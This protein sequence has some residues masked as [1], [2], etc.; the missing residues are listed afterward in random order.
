MEKLLFSDFFYI[1]IRR[2]KINWWNKRKEHQNTI[3][4]FSVSQSYS[5]EILLFFL[6]GLCCSFV[7]DLNGHFWRMNPQRHKIVG[8]WQ[9]ALV[10]AKGILSNGYYIGFVML[11][12]VTNYHNLGGLKQHNR[13][14]FSHS[15][16]VQKSN[17]VLAGPCSFWRL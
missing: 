16:R 5:H 10:R 14:L 8:N 1:K 6:L 7:K 9:F 2:R 17:K 12:Y 11:L 3:S 13:N 4:C 15:S